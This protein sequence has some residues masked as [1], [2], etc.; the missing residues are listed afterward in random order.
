MAIRLRTVNG[1]RIALCAAETKPAAGD[2]YLDDSDHHALMAKFVRDLQS[3]GWFSG[4]SPYE[5]WAVMDT[6][7]THEWDD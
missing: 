1:L 3:E 4:H 7:K 2:I 5:E 6:Q